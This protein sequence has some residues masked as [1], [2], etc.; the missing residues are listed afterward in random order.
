MVWSGS[1]KYKYFIESG[2]ISIKRHFVYIHVVIWTYI[3]SRITMSPVQTWNAIV[4]PHRFSCIIAISIGQYCRWSW[5]I[6]PRGGSPRKCYGIFRK[7][8]FEIFDDRCWE[9]NRKWNMIWR[10]WFIT[11]WIH[12]SYEIIQITWYGSNVII[13][14]LVSI[15]NQTIVAI[16]IIRHRGIARCPRKLYA[17]VDLFGSQIGRS[18]KDNGHGCVV[19][20]PWKEIVCIN[21][22]DVIGVCAISNMDIKIRS[23]FLRVCCV[24]QS[25]ISI[26]MISCRVWDHIPIQLDVSDTCILNEIGR[27]NRCLGT[28]NNT[29]L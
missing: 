26:D 22:S 1:L 20:R 5:R 15:F 16:Y 13:G 10:F 24:N 6:A 12:A 29:R 14:V 17:S 2:F 7:G 27:K 4:I 21:T 8:S 25:T 19:G 9:W 28:A 3:W 18:S 23:L 11:H